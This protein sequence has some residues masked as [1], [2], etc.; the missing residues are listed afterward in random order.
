MMKKTQ[1]RH[2]QIHPNP[3]TKSNKKRIITHR[4]NVHCKGK[5]R[6]AEHKAPKNASDLHSCKKKNPTKK[7]PVV[8]IQAKESNK[9]IPRKRK[10]SNVN[11]RSKPLTNSSAAVKKAKQQNKDIKGLTKFDYATGTSHKRTNSQDG[12][13]KKKKKKAS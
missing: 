3:K 4:K 6:K 1:D 13:K 7:N 12:K 5:E 10:R 9:S 11:C 2:P 8:V